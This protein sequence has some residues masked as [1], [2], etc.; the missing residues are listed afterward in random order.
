MPVTDAVELIVK[1][2]VKNSEEVAV[3]ASSFEADEENLPQLD[4]TLQVHPDDRGRVIGRRGKTIN[5]LRT[6]VKA[7]A[8]KS[9]QRVNIEVLDN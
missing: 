2:L 1:M 8:I 9:Q 6:V 7:A 5:A 4:I 3:Q